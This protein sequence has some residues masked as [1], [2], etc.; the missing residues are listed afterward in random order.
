[1]SENNPNGAGGAGT[2][3]GGG[4]PPEKNSVSYET[5]SKAI[6][7]VKGLKAKL[8]DYDEFKSQQE[9]EKADK[10]RADLEKKGEFQ[11]LLDL[12][13][14]KNKK[15]EN[16]LNSHNARENSRK[17]LS[18]VLSNLGGSVDKKF[19]DLIEFDSVVLKED[20]TVDEYSVGKVVE[21]F[22]ASYPEVI[23]GPDGNNLPNKAPNG[24]PN[25]SG[26]ITESAWKALPAKE[27]KKF[28][29]DQIIWGN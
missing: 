9:K 26:K 3:D 25:G 1:M 13:R 11:K 16:D 24:A 20:G 12:E 6:D 10:E 28:K 17:K 21:K 19:F 8:K 18:A 23:R 2:G 5:Y 22:K 14:E 27:M 29:Q 7:E 4:A 15:L